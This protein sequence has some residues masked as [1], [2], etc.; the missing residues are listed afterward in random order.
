MTMSTPA[1]WRELSRFPPSGS[2]ADCAELIETGKTEGA[3][4]LLGSLA[5]FTVLIYF[6][7]EAAVEELGNE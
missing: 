4:R 2:M 1:F 6:G 5:Y 3:E 7:R